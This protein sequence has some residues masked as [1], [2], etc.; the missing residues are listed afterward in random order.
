M[1]DSEYSI[2]DCISSKINSWTIMD[3]LEMLKLVP[4]HLK[5]EK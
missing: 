1:F 4:D 5:T 3:N 2:E